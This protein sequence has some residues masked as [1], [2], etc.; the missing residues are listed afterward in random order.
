M[1]R[2]TKIILVIFIVAL[3]YF[4]I[5]RVH[6]NETI[7]NGSSLSQKINASKINQIIISNNDEQII[8][9]QDKAKWYCEKLRVKDAVI[10]HIFASMYVLQNKS[11][12][13]EQ[14]NKYNNFM[15]SHK[16]TLRLSFKIKNQSDVALSFLVGKRASHINSCYVL[17]EDNK[18]YLVDQN[19]AAIFPIN[20]E[21]YIDKNI[22]KIQKN[23]LEQVT[24]SIKEGSPSIFKFN[25]DELQA[26]YYLLNSEAQEVKV[27][28]ENTLTAYHLTP[29][30]YMLKVKLNSA[31]VINF[32]IGEK[33]K[34]SYYMYNLARKNRVYRV[35]AGLVD[36]FLK[37]VR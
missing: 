22:L 4:L 36:A 20:K 1:S 27:V 31:H 29:P 35:E 17:W 16:D 2:V 13:S 34:D 15:L 21:E 19:L 7:I 26:I 12:I 14:V 18:V 11:L 5:S 6:F 3:S 10:H 37:K 32:A 23:E 25:K 28:V 33:Y 9:N 8:L 24:L 30:K